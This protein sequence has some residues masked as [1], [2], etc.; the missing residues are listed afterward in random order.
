MEKAYAR[1]LGDE[2]SGELF[3]EILEH[4]EAFRTR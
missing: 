3:E 1:G 4:L 2:Y